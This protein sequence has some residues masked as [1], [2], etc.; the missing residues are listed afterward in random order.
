MTE[1]NSV[2]IDAFNDLRQARRIFDKLNQGP[3][4]EIIAEIGQAHDGSYGSC[5]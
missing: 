3:K 2:N 5:V 4:I 1:K